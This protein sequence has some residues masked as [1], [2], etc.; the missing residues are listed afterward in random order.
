MMQAHSGRSS[1]RLHILSD[2]HLEACPEMD[3]PRVD[4]DVVVLAGDIHNGDRGIRWAAERFSVP[5]IYV[6]GNHEFYGQ[7]PMQRTLDRMREAAE[8]THIHLL[9]DDVV[10]IDGVRFVGGTLWTDFKVMGD[11]EV[12][13]WARREALLYLN[14][15]HRIH[16]MDTRQWAERYTRSRAVLDEQLNKPHDG[17]TVVVTHHA[18]HRGSI[19]PEYVEDLMTAAFVSHLPD[20]VGKADLWI[21]GH[22]HSLFDYTPEDCPDTRVICNPR[23]YAPR[24]KP[25]HIENRKF[26]PDFVVE[27]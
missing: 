14:D 9:D 11:G 18:P 21:H 10:V 26:I 24:D 3:V 17:S 16:G 13:V 15:F 25:W 8:G 4:A 22:T 19:A 1:L 20:L 5:V 12:S 23:G 6:A 2:L 27:V 7:G